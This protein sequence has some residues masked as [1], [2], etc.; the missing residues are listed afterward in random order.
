MPHLLK[1]ED[2]NSM[3]HSVETRLPFIDYNVLETAVSIESSYKIKD[4]WTKYILRK[5]VNDILP[6]S[7]V[8]RKNKLGF[9][10]PTK[11]WIDGMDED[12][13]ISISKSTILKVITGVIDFERLDL[14]Q[15]WKLFNVAKWEEIY[16]VKID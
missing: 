11:S 14:N 13:K 12:I 4:G 3:R 9:G 2:K 16:A 1:Y 10:A 7:I 6:S 15:K 5:V 8:W